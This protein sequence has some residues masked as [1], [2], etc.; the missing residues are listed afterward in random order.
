MLLSWLTG[1][2]STAVSEF[3]DVVPLFFSHPPFKVI[4]A[5]RIDI[6]DST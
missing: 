4:S 5:A 1:S 6:S 3:P 2:G